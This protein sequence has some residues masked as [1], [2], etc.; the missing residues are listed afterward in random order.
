V[1]A[2]LNKV[3]LGEADAGIVGVDLTSGAVQ[4]LVGTNSR[5]TD[6]PLLSIR[7]LL[8]DMA[9]FMAGLVLG[10]TCSSRPAQDLRLT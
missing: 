10:Q 2:V 8:D 6:K 9:R 5:R 4:P 1:R 7:I 3:S